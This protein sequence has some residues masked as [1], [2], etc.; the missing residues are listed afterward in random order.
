M[1]GGLDGPIRSLPRESVARAKPALEER[2]PTRSWATWNS[3][4]FCSGSCV[5]LAAV[6]DRVGLATII[7]AFA[8]GLILAKTER[9]A[10]IEEQIKP[11]AD[12]FA[13]LLCHDRDEGAARDAQPV[14]GPWE[15]GARGALDGRGRARKARRRFGGVPARRSTLAGGSWDDPAR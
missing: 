3:A 13:D 2:F 10:H 6:A 5:L 8:A 11:V 4:N 12:L 14:R 9:R 7:G 15:P 1:G